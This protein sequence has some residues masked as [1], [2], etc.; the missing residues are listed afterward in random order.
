[1]SRTATQTRK[2]IIA[3]SETKGP[4]SRWALVDALAPDGRGDDIVVRRR[5]H[6]IK[7]KLGPDA[8]RNHRGFGYELTDM[9]RKRLSGEP[10]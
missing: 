5:I 4:L 7:F 10:W 6:H 8:I 9:G 2:V 1:M 3:L